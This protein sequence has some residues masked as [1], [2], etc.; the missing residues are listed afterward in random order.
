[1]L[2]SEST[3]KEQSLSSDFI[4]ILHVDDEQDVLF[5]VKYFFEKID[6]NIH[7]DSV[8]SPNEAIKIVLMNSY[9]CIVSD[10]KMPEMN[11][12]ELCK[13][14]KK[15]IDIPFIIYTGWGSEEV[16]VKAFAVGVDDYFRKELDPNHYQVLAKRI[17]SVVEKSKA[18]EALRKIERKYRELVCLSSYMIFDPDDTRILAFKERKIL[19]SI[20]YTE[21]D[22][23]Y[24]S[25]IIRARIKEKIKKILF[26][27]FGE[28]TYER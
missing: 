16:A 17:K 9:D 10:Y 27:E 19:E 18:L 4:Y 8:S 11:G 5:F 24:K 1:V 23:K 3:D 28:K 13:R 6:P 2:L 21:E 26:K 25:D 7:V 14:I 12:I 15:I 20:G 22:F